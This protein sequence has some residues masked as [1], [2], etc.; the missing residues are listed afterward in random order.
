MGWKDILFAVVLFA[1][2]AFFLYRFIKKRKWCPDIYGSGSC[3]INEEK[4]R[5]KK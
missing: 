3:A 2:A 1:A 4:E 5:D